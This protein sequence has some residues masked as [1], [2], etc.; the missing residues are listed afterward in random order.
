MRIGS[1]TANRCI[2]RNDPIFR[3]ADGRL[4]C[5]NIKVDP[6]RPETLK[7]DGLELIARQD[8][9]AVDS[10]GDGT[11]DRDVVNSDNATIPPQFLSRH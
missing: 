3:A 11:A 8:C 7:Y 2:L 4:P 5:H 1:F 10:A 6:G 9:P